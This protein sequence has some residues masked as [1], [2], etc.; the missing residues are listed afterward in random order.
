MNPTRAKVRG[1][2]LVLLGLLGACGGGSG[3]SGGGGRGPEDL[4]GT[5]FA[6]QFS[7]SDDGGP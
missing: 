6:F 3:G 7:G 4:A 5:Y 1:G 2:V